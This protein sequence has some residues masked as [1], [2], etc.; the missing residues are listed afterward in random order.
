MAPKKVDKKS[1]K[2]QLKSLE[3][4]KAKVAEDKTFGLKNKNK[5]KS[6]QKYAMM[7]FCHLMIL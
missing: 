6:V 3:K 7:I 1:E 5:S 2:G 4:Q